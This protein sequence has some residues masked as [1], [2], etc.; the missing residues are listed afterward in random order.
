MRTGWSSCGRSGTKR[1]RRILALPPST[2]ASGFRSVGAGALA[3]LFREAGLVDVGTD[4]LE[5]PTDFASFDDYWTPFLHGTGPAPDYVASLDAPSR[6]LLRERL[7]R[8]LH[9]GTNER[10]QLRARAWAVRGVSS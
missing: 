9:A 7:Q 5:I 1:L 2:K 8:R 3:T 10:I 4:P 6:A